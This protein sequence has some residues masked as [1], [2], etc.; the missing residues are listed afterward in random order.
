M[1]VEALTMS[2]ARWEWLGQLLARISVGLLFFLSGRGKLFV[3]ARRESMRTTMRQAGVPFP[4]LTAGVTSVVEFVFGALLVVGLFTPVSCLLLI[5][6]MVG[7][8]ATTLIPAL[9]AGSA[10]DWL[11]EFLYLPEVLYVVI[12]VWLLLAGPGWL[13]VDQQL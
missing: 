2:L 8:L 11:A 6:V 10:I 9:K 4:E 13:S 1:A 12:L 5:G 3:E 7:A